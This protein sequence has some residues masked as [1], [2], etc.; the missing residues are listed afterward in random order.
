[1]NTIQ[2]RKK[3][4][5]TLPSNFR[6]KYGVEEGEIYSYIDLGE[7]SLLLTR[8]VSQVDILSRRIARS[9][10]ENNVTLEDLL[11]TLDEERRKIFK[12]KYGDLGA[13]TPA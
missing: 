5:F 1:M 13:E 11:E 6:Q 10:K 12:E 8:K 4:T 2:I 7:G 3:G 9:L